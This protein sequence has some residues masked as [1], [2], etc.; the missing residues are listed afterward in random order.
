MYTVQSNTAASGG[1]ADSEIRTVR[2]AM[3]PRPPPPP[4]C[5]L[6][7]KKGRCRRRTTLLERPRRVDLAS[8]RRK[9]RF[10]CKDLLAWVS[11]SVQMDEAAFPPD[12]K[13][14]ID[15]LTLSSTLRHSTASTFKV[16]VV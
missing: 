16:N 9:S 13:V 3:P 10:I 7:S 8:Y 5:A 2:G 11:D 4:R 6:V 15:R 1:A 12:L 14:R